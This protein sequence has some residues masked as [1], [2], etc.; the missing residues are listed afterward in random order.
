M[1]DCP[2]Q[3]SG[4]FCMACEQEMIEEM[5]RKDQERITKD[6]ELSRKNMVEEIMH[7]IQLEK[8]VEQCF[9]LGYLNRE[10]FNRVYKE[11]TE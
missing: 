1:R 9:L 2:C 10:L 11:V 5:K 7:L 8:A 3:T 4:H 6:K